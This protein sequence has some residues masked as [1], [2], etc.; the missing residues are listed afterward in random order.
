MKMSDFKPYN[1]RLIPV[2]E[3]AVKNLKA[4]NMD[5][6][7]LETLIKALWQ[8]DV[9]LF[10]L[11]LEPQKNAK[12]INVVSL[13]KTET[14]AFNDWLI[15]HTK[16]CPRG[17][18]KIEQSSASGIGVLSSVTCSCGMKRDITDYSKW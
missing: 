9:N 16:Y 5:A 17:Y 4:V 11:S 13:H 6:S 18:S 1:Q 15:E 7:A 2:L 10:E 8:Q 14:E 12:E 3:R